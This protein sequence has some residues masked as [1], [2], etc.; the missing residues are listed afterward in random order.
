MLIMTINYEHE[1]DMHV[2]YIHDF[3]LRFIGVSGLWDFTCTLHKWS[4]RGVVVWLHYDMKYYEPMN[5]T[6]P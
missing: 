5:A 3:F 6:L 2:K 1:L 4:Y